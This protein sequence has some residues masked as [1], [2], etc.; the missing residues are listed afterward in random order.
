MKIGW[1][2]NAVIMEAEPARD[3]RKWYFEQVRK[4]QWSKMH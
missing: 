3:T 1:T 2:L 4:Q